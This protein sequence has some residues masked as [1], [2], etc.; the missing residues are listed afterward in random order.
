MDG[1]TRMHPTISILALFFLVSNACIRIFSDIYTTL[2]VKKKDHLY[3]LSCPVVAFLNGPS[4]YE[5]LPM[6]RMYV[7]FY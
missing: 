6:L 3:V 1:A 5:L 7:Y 4:S 2:N